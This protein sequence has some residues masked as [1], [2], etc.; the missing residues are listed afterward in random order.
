MKYNSE[1]AIGDYIEIDTY[2]LAIIRF[3]LDKNFIL[4]DKMVQFINKKFIVVRF[5]S[6]R[7]QRMQLRTCCKNMYFSA[8]R[9]H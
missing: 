9:K 6:L 8:S 4:N 2:G 3:F 7:S 1:V 5:S